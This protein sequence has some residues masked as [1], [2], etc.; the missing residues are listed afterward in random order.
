MRESAISPAQILAD[1]PSKGWS[2]LMYVQKLRV[3]DLSFSTAT[4]VSC[5]THAALLPA[6]ERRAAVAK[7]ER[8]SQTVHRPGDRRRRTE[9]H[10]NIKR[11][12]VPGSTTQGCRVRSDQRIEMLTVPEREGGKGAP[13]S[14][15]CTRQHYVVMSTSS[16][17]PRCV[18][19]YELDRRGGIGSNLAPQKPKKGGGKAKDVTHR[20]CTPSKGSW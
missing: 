19:D 5:S 10:L 1:Q 17:K 20:T 9:Q 4:P 3:Y 6:M 18:A 14:K 12:R 7:C 16:P 15:T 11:M 13:R 2:P 8:V